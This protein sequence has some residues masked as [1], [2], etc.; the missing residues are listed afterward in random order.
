M[1]PNCIREDV[2]IPPKDRQ[3]LQMA[4]QL[5]VDTT[6]TGILHPSNTLTQDGYF[7][8][9]AALVTLTNG[10]VEIHLHNL[11]TALTLSKGVRKLLVSLS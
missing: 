4:S 1:E 11:L 2:T 7:A 3:L 10:Q 5:Y 8:F 9:C 6:I